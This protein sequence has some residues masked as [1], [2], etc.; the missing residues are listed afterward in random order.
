ME[1]GDHHGEEFRVLFRIC[2]EH[3]EQETINENVVCVRKTPT[4]PER[5][6]PRRNWSRS[7]RI[8]TE[9]SSSGADCLWNWSPFGWGAGKSL[10]TDR[11]GHGRSRRHKHMIVVNS[12]IEE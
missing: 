6:P 8:K 12:R 9:G 4:L 3:Q 1:R 11:G 10:I 7:P 5:L 2:Y